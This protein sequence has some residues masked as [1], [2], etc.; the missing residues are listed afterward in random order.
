MKKKLLVLFLS[1]FAFISG[2]N[3][4]E[5]GHGSQYSKA[6]DA[7]NTVRL[8]L[9]ITPGSTEVI[10]QMSFECSVWDDVSGTVG[11]SLNCSFDGGNSTY[12]YPSSP[13]TKKWEDEK[14]D[15]IITNPTTTKKS[16]YVK[17]IAKVV[18]GSTA[19]ETKQFIQSVAD[20]KAKKVEVPKSNVS[21]V[22][23]LTFKRGKMSPTFNKDVLEGY[24]VYD[25]ADTINSVSFEYGC[26][27]ANC[28]LASIEGGQSS[29]IAQAKVVLLKG[30]NKISL[31]FK[32]ADGSTQTKYSFT[33][34]RGETSFNSAK[35][36]FIEV[37][38]ATLEP[39]FNKDGTS[40]SLT[41]P[42]DVKSLKEYLSYE[43]I[44][45][46]A[47]IEVEGADKL[48]EGANVVKINVT[49]VSE[50]ETV[51][52]VLNVTLEDK[53]A[54]KVTSYSD[55]TV[56]FTIEGGEEKVMAESD[57]E[58]K[59]PEEY[60]KI[61]NG[62]Y[63]FDKDGK[64]TEKQVQTTEKTVGEDEDKKEKK[65]SKVGIIILLIV[66]GVA[67]I[68]VSAY[69]IFFRKPKDE[70]DKDKKGKGSKKEDKKEK[71]EEVKEES[72]EE[73]EEKVDEETKEEP[74]EEDEDVQ[75]KKS[76]NRTVD[77]DE[78]LSDLMNTKEYDFKTKTSIKKDDE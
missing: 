44:D 47:K 38:D 30:E 45:S 62:T 55:N 18:N 57:F 60:A 26:T 15:V 24:T 67:I 48:S 13:A 51:T 22:N 39:A 9:T 28:Q 12:V 19:G 21:T 10:T 70:N 32:S 11:S 6:D 52:Y 2:V 8:P 75:F 16:V 14:I 35:L 65:S 59:Y 1:V 23:T 40:Y 43:A 37:K 17:V 61:K 20:V 4:M 33:I 50:E 41:L 49:N 71:D 69:F 7:D 72:K 74:V 77:I 34:Y 31:T 42:T 25:I 66:L 46:N 64:R 63:V 36:K 76:K 54:I 5:L 78:A 73:T 53:K 68:G 56:G 3:A 58:K 29:D 27:E